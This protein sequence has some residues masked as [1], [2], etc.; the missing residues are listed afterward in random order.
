[1]VGSSVPVTVP[2]GNS[3]S[4]HLYKAVPSFQLQHKPFLPNV[5]LG[6]WVLI[7]FALFQTML[8]SLHICTLLTKWSNGWMLEKIKRM[9]LISFAS[10]NS[11]RLWLKWKL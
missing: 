4:Y 11:E 2:W 5:V 9:K 8:I 6:Q 10:E 3:P 7:G 1:M